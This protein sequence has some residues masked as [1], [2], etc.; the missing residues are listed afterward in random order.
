[1]R[2]LPRRVPWLASKLEKAFPNFKPEQ[3]TR[4]TYSVGVKFMTTGNEV[5]I[6]PILYWGDPAWRGT[7]ISK[8]TGEELMTSVPRHLQ[9]IRKRVREADYSVKWK[10]THPKSVSTAA[11][12]GE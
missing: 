11:L 9:F 5:D 12:L 6:V 1:M 8:D 7:L 4:K 2:A 3:V 10:I